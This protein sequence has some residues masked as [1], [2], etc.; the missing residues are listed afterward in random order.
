MAVPTKKQCVKT[1]ITFLGEETRKIKHNNVDIR[2]D[3]PHLVYRCPRMAFCSNIDN[4]GEVS[5]Q[6]SRGFTNHFNHLASCYN[7]KEVLFREVCNRLLTSRPDLSDEELPVF[8]SNERELALFSYIQLIVLRN[9]PVSIVS[10]ELYREYKTY[11]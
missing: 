8:V 4:D 10:D 7:T 2:R 9:A 11:I 3:I 6:K 1:L 5:F